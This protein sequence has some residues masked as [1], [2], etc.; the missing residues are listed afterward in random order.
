MLGALTGDI[1]GSPYMYSNADDKYFEIGKGVR[2][3]HNGREV[4]CHPKTTDKGMLMYAVSRWLTSDEQRRSSRLIAQLQDTVRSHPNILFSPFVSRWA[5][6]ENPRASGHDIPAAMICVIPAAEA[7]STLPEAIALSRQVAEVLSSNEKALNGAMALGQAIWMASHG[8]SKEDIAFAMENDFH[9]TPNADRME[10]EARLMGAEL[11][12]IIINGEET[13]EFYLKDTGKRSNETETLLNAALHAFLKGEDFEDTVRRSVALGGQS[14]SVCAM[15][16]ALS[17]SFY[18]AVPEKLKG[19]CSTYIP[20]EIRSQISS[21]E[22]ICLNRSQNVRSV[23]KRPDNSFNVIRMPD[24]SKIF[25]VPSYRKDI[26]D[27][28]KGRFGDDAVIVKPSAAQEM[29]KTMIDSRPGGTYLV[30]RFPDVRTLYVQDGQICGAVGLKGDH[31]PPLEARKASR[32]AFLMISDHAAKIRDQLQAR[33]GYSGEG[34]IHFENA[35]FPIVS[36][37]KVEVWKGD[38]FAGSVGIDPASGLLKLNHGGDFGPM[39]WFGERTDSVFNS[40]NVDS[41]KQALGHYCLDEGRGVYDSNRPLNVEVAN[42][43]VARSK[44]TRLHEAVSE[45]KSAKQTASIKR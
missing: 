8:R 29:L 11:E 19:L 20:S 16:G 1:I 32:Q 25:V 21:F 30:D 24:E 38:L 36:Y 41:V 7:A 6:S 31:L 18:G 42:Q 9:L 10:I 12:P 22:A 17:E 15:A 45:S 3:W 5:E 27:V 37:D 35:Y 39:E 4:T 34:C 2:A 28:I 23:A 13:G 44:D 33:T 14:E 40:V 26:I 43:D